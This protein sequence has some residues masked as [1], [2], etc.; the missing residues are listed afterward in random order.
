MR[1]STTEVAVVGVGKAAPH[2]L[3]RLPFVLA[4]AFAAFVLVESTDVMAQVSEAKSGVVIACFHKRS[5]RFSPRAHPSRCYLRG[6]RGTKVAGIPIKGI[7]WGH[8]GANPTRAAYG[9]DVR[10]GT[11]VRV[12]AYRPVSCGDGP[13]WYSRAVVV[14][15]GS[16]NGFELRLPTCASHR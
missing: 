6:Y 14:F 5:H 1:R 8:W 15:A 7:K 9:K 10:D 11:H 4:I 16:G 3:L 12:I 2:R 13:A